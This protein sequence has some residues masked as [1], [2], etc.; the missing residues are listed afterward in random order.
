[1]FKA[2]INKDVASD[3]KTA[4]S[5][6]IQNTTVAAVDFLPD[7]ILLEI[8]K[9][10]AFSKMGTL[11]RVCLR[12]RRLA[13]DEVLWRKMFLDHYSLPPCTD[14]PPGATSWR[15]EFRRLYDEAPI[16][17]LG[18][19]DGLNSIFYKGDSTPLLLCY[20]DNPSDDGVDGVLENISQASF[21][22]DGKLFALATMYGG[23]G[24][25]KLEDPYE[26][27][28]IKNKLF[29]PETVR[30]PAPSCEFNE[31]DTLLLVNA[32]AHIRGG[33]RIAVLSIAKQLEVVCTNQDYDVTNAKGT[34]YSN[35]YILLQSRNSDS[36]L[37]DLLLVK[38]SDSEHAELNGLMLSYHLD[39]LDYVK[40]YLAGVSE[41]SNV[42]DVIPKTD[43][44]KDIVIDKDSAPDGANEEEA[45]DGRL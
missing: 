5:G 23:V 28:F 29:D 45:A 40:F 10:I 2:I 35:E 27:L 33:G 32:N 36:S 26:P 44:R 6:T 3:I 9:N 4:L 11:A 18:V 17:R 41:R 42:D 20:F 13:T 8:F 43:L 16:F 34:W 39:S 21:S 7:S 14:M 24:V 30:A 15:L 19:D 31:S 37:L 1:M 22:H 12:W 38:V 25:W